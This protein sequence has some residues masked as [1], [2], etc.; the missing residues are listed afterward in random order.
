MNII[1]RPIKTKNKDGTL[2]FGIELLKCYHDVF[3]S[4]KEAQKFAYLCNKCALS[5][6]HFEEAIDDYLNK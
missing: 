3:E 1:Y 6:V 5:E 4:E 2:T